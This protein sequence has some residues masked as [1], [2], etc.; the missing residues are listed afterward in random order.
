MAAFK[1][2][3]FSV[4]SY[5]QGFTHWH[6]RGHDDSITEV[7]AT[8]Y[9]NNVADMIALHDMILVSCRDGGLHLFVT[10][11]GETIETA[12]MATTGIV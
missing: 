9:F 4:L 7:A 11:V 2:R 12:I 8:G 3:N 1:I 6:Y 10:R 5:A